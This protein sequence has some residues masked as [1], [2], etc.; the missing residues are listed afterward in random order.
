MSAQL[1]QLVILGAGSH[2]R[3]VREIAL[4]RCYEVVAAIDMVLRPELLAE[5]CD[6]SIWAVNGLGD[7][8]HRQDAAAAAVRRGLPIA[9]LRHPNASISP[10][11]SVT[12]GTVVCAMARVS[13][14]ARIDEGVLINSGAI[15]DHDCHVGGYAHIAPGAV[16]CGSVHVGAGA[17]V[18]AGA[19]VLHGV[20]IGEWA[21][22]G[23]GA[24]VTR[25]VAAGETWVGVPARKVG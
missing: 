25:D 8:R 15:V 13:V 20:Q 24:V 1:A 6:Q 5:F 14:N 19:T 3:V 10:W 17:L 2:A 11:A 21:V 12:G 18:G 9:S 4:L 7:N 16:L 22:I 23:A